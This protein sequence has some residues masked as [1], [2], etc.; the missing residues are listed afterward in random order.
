MLEPDG[1]PPLIQIV[2]TNSTS[3]ILEWN[4]VP[5]FLQNGIIR[6]YKII[7][8][9]P[10]EIEEHTVRVTPGTAVRGQINKL[11]R[12]TEYNFRLL[13]FTVKGDGSALDWLYVTPEDGTWSVALLLLLNSAQCGWP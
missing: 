7:Y 13:A 10:G 2:A 9:K 8:K 3:L 4:P 5:I 1:A 11:E 12:F 6:G